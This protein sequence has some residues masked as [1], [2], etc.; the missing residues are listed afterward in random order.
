MEGRE[1]REDGGRGVPGPWLLVAD[2]VPINQLLVVELL[3]KRGYAADAVADGAAAVEALSRTPYAAVLMDIQMPRMDGHEATREIRRREPPGRRTPII[4]VTAHT[5]DHDRQ[6]A[7]SAGMDDYIPKPVRREQ[8]DRVLDRWVSPTPHRQPRE[9]PD[10]DNPLDPAVLADLRTI[11]NE[12]GAPIVAGL[13][14]A[15]DKETPPLLKAL[16]ETAAGADAPAFKR[17]AHA[18]NGISRGVGA[19]RVA[20]TCLELEILADGGNLGQTPPHLVRLVQEWEDA[21][22]ALATGL[23]QT[24]PTM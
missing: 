20:A 17:A 15:F 22:G 1:G 21:R 11:R 13:L 24:P 19:R 14:D 3:K 2:D 16:R 10:T 8:L 12:G 5:R 18:L 6:R 4:A 9:A 23:S 7:I